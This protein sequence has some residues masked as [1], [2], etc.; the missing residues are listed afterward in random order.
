MVA[1]GVNRTTDKPVDVYVFG[2]GALDVRL[3]TLRSWEPTPVEIMAEAGM[4]LDNIE[5]ASR[6]YG[7]ALPS[8]AAMRQRR[9]R[10]SEVCDSFRIYSMD[11]SQTS[12]AVNFVTFRYKLAGRGQR[13][14]AGFYDPARISD[15]REWLESK[16]G[17]L[18][19]FETVRPHSPNGMTFLRCSP[20]RRLAK[21]FRSNG[22]VEPA[23][24]PMWYVG[25][26]APIENLD[27]LQDA[28]Q[29]AL[30]MNR[31]G[32]VRG[33][34]IGADV[35]WFIRRLRYPDFETGDLPT[36]ADDPRSWLALDIDGLDAQPELDLTDLRACGEAAIAQ[37]PAEFH[38]VDC[39]VQATASHGIKPGLRLRLWLWLSHAITCAEAKAWLEDAPCDPAVFNPVQL[40]YTA[41]PLF[42]GRPDHL[43]SR[44]ARLPGRPVVEVP[45]ITSTSPQQRA[46]H[47]RTAARGSLS[48]LVRT[49]QNAESGERHSIT[50]WAACRAGELVLAGDVS[51]EGAIEDIAE[52]ALAA[53]LDA[54]EAWDTARDGVRRGMHDAAA[55][56]GG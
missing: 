37:L 36:L 32:A 18:A 49:V 6:A 16:L 24:L 22:Q 48:A 2:D 4:I 21:R 40:I 9:A 15:P 14:A 56:V 5:H 47:S 30:S 11:E 27:E 51:E 35:I 19:M 8:A 54:Q 13:L 10:A 3:D 20:M 50:F 39:V 46:A 52:A 42:E 34:L 7:S 33:G 44:L 23:Q 53:G 55:K 12:D 38:G 31:V 17:G 28:L 26:E 25:V 41:A 43:P 1:R 45:A 29:Q